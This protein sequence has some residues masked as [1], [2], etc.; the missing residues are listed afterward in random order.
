VWWEKLK[1]IREIKSRKT[2]K[3][4]QQQKNG[5]SEIDREILIKLTGKNERGKSIIKSIK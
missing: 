5:Q 2:P 3:K 1:T 4:K